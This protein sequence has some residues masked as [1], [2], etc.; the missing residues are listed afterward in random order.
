VGCKPYLQKFRIGSSWRYGAAKYAFPLST[1]F[2]DWMGKS[3]A[4]GAK[5]FPDNAT[6][7]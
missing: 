1:V 3:R 4:G 7:K 2:R 6:G 5:K